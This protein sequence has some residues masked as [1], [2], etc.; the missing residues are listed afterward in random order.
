M[1]YIHWTFK[2]MVVFFGVF[3]IDIYFVGHEKKT[4]K[5]Y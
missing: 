3:Y 2:C 1:Y 4:L 5:I